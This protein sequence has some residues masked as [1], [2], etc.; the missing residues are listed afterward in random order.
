LCEVGDT[1]GRVSVHATLWNV[2]TRPRA[3]VAVIVPLISSTATEARNA[4][5]PG[6]RTRGQSAGGLG[7]QSRGYLRP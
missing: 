1:A 7:T 3:S 2:C 6:P 4:A 5:M